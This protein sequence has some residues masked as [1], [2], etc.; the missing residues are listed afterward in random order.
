MT[1]TELRR[2]LTLAAVLLLSFLIVLCTTT[3]LLAQVPADPT[4][5]WDGAITAP[6]GEV[7]MAIDLTRDGSDVKG[8]FT[9]GQ[10]KGI[11]LGNVVMDGRAI[12]LKIGRET[13]Q[14]ILFADGKTISGD[15]NGPAGSAPFTLTRTG[16]AIVEPPMRNPA[17]ASEFEG[18][19]GGAL[20]VQG[21]TLRVILRI[22]NQTDG[23]SRA[24]LVSV[25]EG[26]LEMPSAVAQ[27]GLNLTLN[28]KM[29]GGAY[30]AVLNKAH[31]ELAGT[32]TVQGMALP[33]TLTRTTS[34]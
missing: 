27:Q 31:T 26:G 4:G 13:F 23:T 33:L 30:T 22:A 21:R 12:T 7:K 29:T 32:Y 3:L 6:F 5:H 2:P 10:L 9:A 1:M 34:D 17:I 8:T 25:D 19:W 15:Y 11:P 24:T 20:D 28:V 14:G 18:V 16:D